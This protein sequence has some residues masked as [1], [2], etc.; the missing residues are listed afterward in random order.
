MML[1]PFINRLLIAFLA[2]STLVLT[3]CSAIRSAPAKNLQAEDIEV[4]YRCER[5][6]ILTVTFAEQGYTTI[7]GGKHYK[8]R[9]H[10]KP[11]VAI[12]QFG[13]NQTLTL[14]QEV[15]GSGFF[16]SNGQ[17]ALRGKGN[18]AI[19]TIGKM[20]DEHCVAD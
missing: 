8:K 2:V 12:V 5:G 9:Y 14:T 20:A 17:Y 19:W 13:D 18:E 10:E 7:H 6:S 4:V 11:S 15:S 16:Y 1:N 3:A